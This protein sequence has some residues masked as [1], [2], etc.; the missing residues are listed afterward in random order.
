MN[1]PVF[2]SPWLLAGLAAVGL[3]VLIH[4]LTRARPRRIAFPPYR[5]LVEACA[6]RQAVHRLRTFLLLA[7]RCLAILFLVLL[8]SR[9]FLKPAGASAGADAARRVVLVVDASLSMR[10]VQRGVPLF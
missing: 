4:Y 1:W 8:F 9:P 2:T 10:A 5:F 3:P 7:V 6:G